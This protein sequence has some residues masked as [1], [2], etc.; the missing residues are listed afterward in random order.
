MLADV[1]DQIALAL[2]RLSELSANVK[3]VVV[4]NALLSEDLA[5]TIQRE[6]QRKK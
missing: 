5:K 3:N 6:N 1:A 4:A 2:D